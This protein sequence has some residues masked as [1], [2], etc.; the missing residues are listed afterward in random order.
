MILLRCRY[1]ASK[2]IIN[3]NILNST[4]V[5]NMKERISIFKTEISDPSAEILNIITIAIHINAD[6]RAIY[7]LKKSTVP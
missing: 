3:K 2:F 1:I 6:K 5:L 4:G 7:G